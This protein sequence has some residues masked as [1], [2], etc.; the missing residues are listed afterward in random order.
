MAKKIPARAEK[1]SVECPH[2]DT[3]QLEPVNAKSTYCR[4]CSKY[5]DLE[6]MQASGPPEA[7]GGYFLRKVEA[8]LGRSTT[9]TVR[10][11]K[12]DTAHEVDSHSKTTL[13]TKCGTHM[14]L[15]DFK[16]SA[17]FTGNISTQGSIEIT[18]KGELNCQK[19]VCAEATVQ[20]QVYGMLV[21][22]TVHLKYK[23]LLLCEIEAQHMI[24]DRG[25]ETDLAHTINV[26]SAQI[27][28]HCSARIMAREIVTI[29]KTG[30][31]EGTVYA[32]SINIEQ[33]GIFQGE[34]FIGQK[35]L[36]QAELLPLDPGPSKI[37]EMSK[38]KRRAAG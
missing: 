31:L 36:S 27:N 37:I 9:K 2:C 14:D 28:G 13:C 29:S 5:I 1:I 4:K 6:K 38:A 17:P 10:C 33:G 24:V 22:D 18:P 12:C 8:F 21:C 3:P 26:I 15:R 20:G 32:K 30:W 23:G 34:L 25:A 35:E 19:A 7:T 16:I 11:Q